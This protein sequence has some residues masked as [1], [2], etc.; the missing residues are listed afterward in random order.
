MQVLIY[1]VTCAICAYLGSRFVVWVVKRSLPVPSG[2]L[3]AIR[4][5][6]WWM[7]SVSVSFAIYFLVL[8]FGVAALSR[9]WTIQSEIGGGVAQFGFLILSVPYWAG[10]FK[11]IDLQLS[12][13]AAT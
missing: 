11:G 9:I 7:L 10:L 8:F 3:S 5:L 12:T 13:K 4:F 6:F 1:I 2:V